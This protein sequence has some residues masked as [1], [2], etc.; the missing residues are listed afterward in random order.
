MS[1][2]YDKNNKSKFI[3]P[4]IL[5][6]KSHK[7]RLTK[8]IHS[9][10]NS[11]DN[12]SITGN[13]LTLKSSLVEIFSIFE[14][15]I[16]DII[17]VHMTFLKLLNELEHRN[18][19]NKEDKENIQIINLIRNS[20]IHNNSHFFEIRNINKEQVE[21][22]DWTFILQTDDNLDYTKSHSIKLVS[23]EKFNISNE[24]IMVMYEII[25]NTAI[26]LLKKI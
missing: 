7:D 18:L 25:Y 24:I 4:Q 5:E 20:I 10:D 3:N 8:Q 22:L 13:T 15:T 12:N 19:L 11:L 16:R 1:I 21:Q 23:Y 6:L 9:M 14:F 2:K 17:G 26:K